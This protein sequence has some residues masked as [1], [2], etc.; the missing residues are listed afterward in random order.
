MGFRM[1]LRAMCGNFGEERS[2]SHA[3]NL[4]TIPQIYVFHKDYES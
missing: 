3:E 2:P 4:T 1:G